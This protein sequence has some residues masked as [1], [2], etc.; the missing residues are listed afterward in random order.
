MTTAAPPAPSPLPEL[1]VA[2]LRRYGRHLVIPEV[3][4][5]GQRRLK[6]ASVLLVGA[7]GLGSPLALYLAAAGVGRLGMVEFDQVDESNLQRQVLYG[8]AD[9]GTPKLAA[10]T[11]RLAEVNPHVEVVPHAVRLTAANALE[12]LAPYDVVADGSDNFA[13][14]YLVNDACA[15]LG[16]PDVFGAVHRFEGQLSVF[17]AAEGPCYRCLFPEPPPPG[18]IPS[19]AEAGVLGVLPGIIGALQANE[20]IKLA[21]GVGRPLVGRLLLFDALGTTFRE[22]ALRKDPDCPVCAPGARPELVDYEELCGSAPAPAGG[23]DGEAPWEIAPEELARWRGEGRDLQLLDVREP[24]E[25]AICSL[26]GARRVPLR[27]LPQRLAEL[28]RQRPLVAYC[29]HGIRSARAVE[30]LR[31]EGFQA[32]NLA[33]GI[34]A[35]SRQVDP[36]LPRY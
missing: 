7:G 21:L 25:Q 29:H 28:D 32:I 9:V 20:V 11:A 1:T 34:D 10:A 19:C 30:L 2:E 4:P 16:K 12:L 13:A 6:G 27:Q 24:F 14:R 18:L 5:D 8:S 31:R 15:L 17:W 22:L 35:W 26:Q 36:S 33:G 23:D 3:G